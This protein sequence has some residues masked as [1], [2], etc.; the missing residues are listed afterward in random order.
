MQRHRNTTPIP[1]KTKAKSS[2]SPTIPLI[3]SHPQI[4]TPA[5][6]ADNL[7]NERVSHDLLRDCG[8]NI[9]T[10]RRFESEVFAVM[11]ELLDV[12][13]FQNVAAPGGFR[14]S[15]R[16]EVL[17]TARWN[18]RLDPAILAGYIHRRIP[19]PGAGA[20]SPVTP[21]NSTFAFPGEVARNVGF[22]RGQQVRPAGLFC[23]YN[24]RA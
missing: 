7:P 4:L 3:S 17:S 18:K 16:R 19:T 9:G 10:V 6:R 20:V 15:R 12:E 23:F 8:V 14:T 21:K 13:K 1:I 22:R 5:F 11:G 24:R 2:P